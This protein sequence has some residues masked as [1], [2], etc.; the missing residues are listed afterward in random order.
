LRAATALFNARVLSRP[1]MPPVDLSLREGAYSVRNFPD[2][3][4]P[5]PIGA[6]GIADDVIEAIAPEFDLK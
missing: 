5:S 6:H 4:H 3:I 2:G 1:D